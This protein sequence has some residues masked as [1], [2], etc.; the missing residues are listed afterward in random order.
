MRNTGELKLNLPELPGGFK[1]AVNIVDQGNTKNIIVMATQGT[2]LFNNEERPLNVL[3]GLE[4][5]VDKWSDYDTIVS[6]VQ[7]QV[8]EV[9]DR[10]VHYDT[11]ILDWRDGIEYIRSAL[12]SGGR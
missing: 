5:Q 8:N 11:K 10:V 1:W 4:I 12:N 6:E 2:Y 9:Y 3:Y 7:E